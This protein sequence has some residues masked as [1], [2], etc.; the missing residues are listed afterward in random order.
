MPASAYTPSGVDMIEDSAAAH[1][2]VSASDG[3]IRI[4]A[5]AGTRYSVITIDGLE[6]ASGYA[7]DSATLLPTDHRG[8]LIVRLTGDG[9]A[10]AS[11]HRLLLN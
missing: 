4:E 1:H 3:V 7:S 10:A 11:T 9:P 5:P 2:S 6:I 8:I